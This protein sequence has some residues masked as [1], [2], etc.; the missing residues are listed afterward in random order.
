MALIFA[1]QGLTLEGLADNSVHTL[2]VCDLGISEGESFDGALLLPE[3]VQ[4]IGSLLVKV[5]G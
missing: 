1:G 2:L 4:D 3:T 5:H